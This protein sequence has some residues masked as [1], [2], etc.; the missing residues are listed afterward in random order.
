[1]SGIKYLKGDA[2]CPQAKGMKIICHVCNDAG[3]WGKGFVLALSKRW[4]EPLA[5]PAGV[6]ADVTD[7]LH[8]LRLRAGGI[9][10][11]VLDLAHCFRLDVVSQR[12]R[13]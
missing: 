2:T 8:A 12:S 6:V 11:Q 5:P 7:D 13:Q 3:G 1:M 10:L 4:D 9:T